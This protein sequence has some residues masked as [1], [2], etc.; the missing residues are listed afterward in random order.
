MYKRFVGTCE[1]KHRTSDIIALN[2]CGFTALRDTI[3][4]IS[5]FRKSL[6]TGW[7][8]VVFLTQVPPGG[9]FELTT[10]ALRATPPVNG[11]SLKNISSQVQVLPP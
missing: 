3:N 2:Y 8:T 11:N 9:S 6:Q 10:P 5:V 7:E 1:E 4:R